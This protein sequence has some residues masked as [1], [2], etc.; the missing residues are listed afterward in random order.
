MR[1]YWLAFFCL[2]APLAH[3]E[4]GPVTTIANSLGSE[5]ELFAGC[6]KEM[7]K[8]KLLAAPSGTVRQIALTCREDGDFDVYLSYQP[9]GGKP[10]DDYLK[11]VFFVAKDDGAEARL[12]KLVAEIAVDAAGHRQLAFIKYKTAD[13]VA[14]LTLSLDGFSWELLT[15]VTYL[16]KLKA[17]AAR[18]P[19]VLLSKPVSLKL[20]EVGQV[21][22]VI[23]TF[24]VASGA[25]V[26]GPG[27]SIVHV[28]GPSGEALTRFTKQFD[29][30][31]G[32]L[33]GDFSAFP[34]GKD[35]AALKYVSA[36]TGQGYTSEKSAFFR[37]L[38]KERSLTLLGLAE[39]SSN[40]QESLGCSAKGQ[41][42][43][44]RYALLPSEKSTGDFYTFNLVRLE[45]RRD[46][47]GN[48]QKS[49][50]KVQ[51]TCAFDAARKD[52]NCPKLPP[53]ASI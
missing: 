26:N 24:S 45:V 29:G 53:D 30:A 25:H 10:N 3:A 49:A 43:E 36:Y 28:I 22:V 52:Y 11:E 27:L 32:A 1:R 34:I 8:P 51:G 4:G 42:R 37:I 41:C 21:T 44:V 38:L 33:S 50:E 14:E 9:Q 12:A 13:A 23:T 15:G 48:V 19:S 2:T 20:P 16:D 46:K 40:S 7:K 17:F 47:K 31:F 5:I 39:G 18:Q 35:E 6:T